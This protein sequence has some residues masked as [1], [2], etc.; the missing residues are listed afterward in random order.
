MQQKNWKIATENFRMIK[1]NKYK[2]NLTEMLNKGQLFD[3]N[4]TSEEQ[5]M[6]KIIEGLL[7]DN[8]KFYIK[9]M[10]GTNAFTA[11]KEN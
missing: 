1:E 4:K 8:G 11:K 6:D 3:L 5:I 2:F 7:Q 9:H 10:P